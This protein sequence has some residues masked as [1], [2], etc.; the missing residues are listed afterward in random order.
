MKMVGTILVVWAALLALTSRAYV[1]RPNVT[2]LS[3][4]NLDFAMNLYR[5]ISSYHDDNI[6]FSPLCMSTAFVTLSMGAREFT[7]EQ[8]L[9][10]LNL[11]ALD[12]DGAGLIPALF[13]E[14]LENVTQSK[15]LQLEQGFA[16]FVHDDFEVSTTFSN[17]IKDFFRADVMN[18]N[19]A[20]HA[21]SKA[22]IN[23]YMKHKTRNKITEAL[24]K[25][26]PMT[27][28]ILINTIFFQGMWEFP[29]DVKATVNDRF[30]VDKYNIVQV[31]MMFTEAK[32]YVTKDTNLKLSIAKLP[33]VGGAAMLILLP[34]K[35][36]D[37]TTIDDRINGKV[38]LRWL[39]QLTKRRTEL[40]MPRFKMEQSYAMHKILPDLGIINVFTSAAN[41]SGL[42]TEQG[43]MV[44]E[45]QHKAMIEVDEMG[46]TAAA[47]TVT[48]ITPYSLPTRFAVDRPFFFFIYHE[49][50]NAVLFMGRVINPT[51][52]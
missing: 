10:G 52:I 50:T 2:E 16:L 20:N 22:A 6:F 26:E 11:A 23:E 17:Q 19:F 40:I 39:K 1:T 35:N 9:R 33:Y 38:F 24:S 21:L 4:S 27:Q 15:E 41:L 7:R 49:V 34:D 28:L 43:L 48:G 51:K 36:V 47:V 44:S 18:V 42:S 14:L 32:I 13:Q 8:I 30:Y 46:T 29:F 45:V 12:Q 3:S 37:Y 25:I 5:R 31:P